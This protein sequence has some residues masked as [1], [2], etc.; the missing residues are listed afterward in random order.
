M[1]S[2]RKAVIPVAGLGTRF[3]PATLA[4][5]KEMLPIVDRPIILYNAEELI[6]ADISELI[7]ITGEGKQAIEKFFGAPNEIEAGLEQIGKLDLIKPILEMRKRLRL[8]PVKQGQPLGLGHAVL[9]AEKAI[10]NEPFAVLLGD[11]VMIQKPGKASATAQLCKI[12]SDTSTS[13]VAVMEVPA[14]DVVKYGICAVT[15]KGPGLWN[16]TS[17]VE[18]PEAGKAPSRLALPGRYIFD[19][20]IFKCLKDVKPG[21]LGEIQL[22]DG[23]TLLAQR[24]GLLAA[25]VDAIRFDAGDKLG[26]LQANVEMALLHPEIG[27]PFKNY[28]MLKFGG[29]KS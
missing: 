3:L 19:A 14:A 12:F 23:M 8:I 1:A 2:I 18:K 9:C 6:A 26:F 7:L 10:G 22:T 20:E 24:K 27:A 25:T 17:V 28:L 15:E 4:V 13:T 11:E 21:R 5:P 16:V 29:G